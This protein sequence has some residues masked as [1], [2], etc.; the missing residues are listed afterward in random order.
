M[1]NSLVDYAVHMIVA[2]GVKYMFSFLT[3][4]DQLVGLKN[5]QLM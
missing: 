1:F 2:Q 4:F 3:A 5:S